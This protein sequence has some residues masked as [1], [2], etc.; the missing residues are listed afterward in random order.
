MRKFIPIILSVLFILPFGS[1]ADEGMWLPMFIKRLNIDDMQS[2][3]LQL[4][5]EEIYSI[6]SASIKDA[7]VSFSGYCTGEIISPKGLLLTN[8]H[9]GFDAIQNHS[10]GENDYLANGFWAKSIDEE[11]PNE[12]MFVDFLIRMEDVSK[13]VLDSIDYNTEE[14]IRDKLIKSRIETIK[15]REIGESNYWA[16]IKSFFGGNEYYMFIYERYNDVR[17][18][19]APPES[20]GK[21][22][23][24]TDNW[25]W[26][27]HTGDF[28]LF[29]VYSAPDGSPAEYSKENIPLKPKHHLPISLDGVNNDD[30]TMIMGYPGGTDRYLPSFGVKEA[31]NTYNP[32]VVKVREAKLDILN[33]HMRADRD[34]NIMYASKKA[35]ISNYWKYYIGQTRGLKRLDVYTKKLN[36]ES[37]FQ[38]FANSSD[39]NTEIYGNVLSTMDSSYG[40]LSKTTLS[41]IYLNEAAWSGPSFIRLARRSEAFL[42]ALNSGCKETIES[43]LDKFKGQVEDN[44]K[45]YKKEIDKELFVKMMEMYYLGVP[46]NQLPPIIDSLQRKHRGDFQRWGNQ[47]YNKSIFV[48]AKKMDAFF[49]SFN[50]NFADL[51]SSIIKQDPA[52]KLQ[53]GILNNYFQTIR[54][55]NAL[56]QKSLNVANRLFIDGLRKMNPDQKFYPDANFT[57]RLTYGSVGDYAPGDAVDYSFVTTLDG[58]MEKMDNDNPE[59]I[60]PEKLVNLYENKDYGIYAGKDNKLNVCFISNNDI[61]G[62]NSGSPVINSKGHLIGC[63]FDGNW[64]A[65]SGDIAFEHELQRTISVDARYIVFIIDKFAEAS[66]IIDELTLVYNNTSNSGVLPTYREVWM[67]NKNGV[68]NKYKTKREFIVDAKSWWKKNKN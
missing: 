18:V 13:E 43:A 61:T 23:G 31:I 34:V 58:V 25:M 6:N 57:M 7:V 51:A 4:T 16:E 11:L 55:S 66:N 63:A 38:D 2:K 32:N 24:D 21:F 12:G 1:S 36:I 29:R 56:A 68:Q 45:E 28:A 40:D 67:S 49:E 52:F 5:A 22:G 30:F 15:E 65:M 42:R 27:R 64:E 33:R 14:S 20:I 3:G 26:P 19:G 62:G 48:D 8:H 47:L 60:V 54:P 39:L 17:L 46:E 9:C 59:F 44:F 41:R 50:S 53:K 35:R 37:S 10:L